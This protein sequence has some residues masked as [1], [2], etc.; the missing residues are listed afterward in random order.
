MANRPKQ[1][2]AH[3]AKKPVCFIGQQLQVYFGVRGKEKEKRSRELPAVLD[4]SGVNNGSKE[5][6]AL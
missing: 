1:H 3:A 4:N 5:H 2:T 6:L